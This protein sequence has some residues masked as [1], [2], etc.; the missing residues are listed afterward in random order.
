[1]E[2]HGSNTLRVNTDLA[3][4]KSDK[5]IFNNISAESEAGVNYV[6]IASDVTFT[7]DN[8]TEHV[9]G[10]TVI[11]E[12]KETD[13]A[14]EAE[15]GLDS[16]EGAQNLDGLVINADGSAE[17]SF[18]GKTSTLDNPLERYNATPT[19]ISEATETG[20][21]IVITGI[22]F[23]KAGPSEGLMTS[24]DSQL[25]MR[26]FWRIDNSTLMQR[27]GELRL[28]NELDNDGVWVR[29]TKGEMQLDSSYNRRF[30]QDYNQFQIG[31]DE[32]MA[33]NGGQL[34]LGGAISHTYGN[35]EYVL[36]DGKAKNTAV[37][38]Y[39]TWLGDKGHYYDLVARVGKLETKFDLVDLSENQIHGDYN[40]YHY[41]VSG[42][43]GYRK[44]FTGGYFIEPQ[45]QLSLGHI[46]G[47]NYKLSNGV[48]MKQS[49]I[50][51]AL[52][53]LGVLTGREFEHGNAYVKASVLKDI[54]G[55]GTVNGYYDG[56]NMSV[57]TIGNKAWYEVGIG[58]NIKLGEA[59]NYYLDV[60]KSF[61]GNV[62]QKWQINTGVS[63]SF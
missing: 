54:G 38:Y 19:V 50:N 28:Q 1:M 63:W 35:V 36:G 49:G 46:Q 9:E 37:A 45:V 2:L 47:I 56:K 16:T 15:H 34:Y 26:N 31:Y 53:R 32:K 7:G 42:E 27:L 12:I 6:E 62:K 30:K 48:E 11:V 43:Y 4:N 17:M 61:G 39:A 58:T 18:V 21:D 41:G 5:L 22:D 59:N 40:T 55:K 14:L 51:S 25:A 13:K 60:S 10:H 23:E 20:R 33:Y 24:V 44:L 3:N 57:D 29:Y 8:D 52:V